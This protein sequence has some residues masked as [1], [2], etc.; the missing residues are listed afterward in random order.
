MSHN[1]KTSLCVQQAR[2]NTPAVNINPNQHAIEREEDDDSYNL[3]VAIKLVA[4][5]EKHESEQEWGDARDLYVEAADRFK[6]WKEVRA[7]YAH[8]QRLFQK[9]LTLYQ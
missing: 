6:Q 1:F 5:A 4:Q 8:T 2:S 9:A 3:K 7:K